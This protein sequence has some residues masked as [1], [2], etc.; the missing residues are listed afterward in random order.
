M[1]TPNGGPEIEADTISL[2]KECLDGM[3]EGGFTITEFKIR[4]R[5]DEKL[6]QQI[7]SDTKEIVLEDADFRELCRIVSAYKWNNRAPFLVNFAMEFDS[8]S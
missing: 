1:V 3:P 4:A 8:D 7:G 6:N 2:L 5:L